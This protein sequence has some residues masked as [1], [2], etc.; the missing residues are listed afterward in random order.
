S[1]VGGFTVHTGDRVT[2]EG[3]HMENF[4]SY[5]TSIGSIIRNNTFEATTSRNINNGTAIVA[6]RTDRYERNYGNKVYGNTIIG[7][8]SGIRMTNSDLEVY[9][10]EIINCK[11]GLI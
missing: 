4:V 5:S 3:N 10:N 7:Y 6:G 11:T 9:D 8:S 1:R 2:I